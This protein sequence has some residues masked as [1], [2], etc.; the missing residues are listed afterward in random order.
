M[1]DER[2]RQLDLTAPTRSSTPG[3]APLLE[4]DDLRVHFAGGRRLGGRHGVV[5]RAVDGVSF[6]V[7]SG[8]TV[9]VV[10]ES[11]CGKTTLARAI[12]RVNTPT[13]GTIRFRGIDVFA[14]TGRDLTEIRKEIQIVFQ[15]ATSAMNPRMRVA[16]IIGE[17]LRTHAGETTKAERRE[18]VAEL[19][20]LVSLDPKMGE[21]HPH[22]CSGGQRQ[23]IAIARAL[24]VHPALIVCDES[25]A[26]LDVSIQA[27]IINLLQDLKQQLDVA[28][29]FISHDL[30]VV[31]HIA[32]RVVVMYLGRVV[33][34]GPVEK[35]LGDP[36][37]PYTRGLLEAVPVPDPSLEAGRRGANVIRGEVA[38]ADASTTG[39]A[40]A[41]RCPIASKE[42][43]EVTPELRLVALAH[44][45]ACI[46]APSFVD[47]DDNAT[48]LH[49]ADPPARVP[50]GTR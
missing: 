44:T 3:S 6:A 4:V 18:R 7:E 36:Q 17:P 32:D 40:F 2:E 15:D 38:L 26:A 9:A 50:N 37:H 49:R 41:A 33:E 5:V 39:C 31:Y 27:Q 30:S 22:V 19:M 46:K 47:S 8:E 35:V 20:Q 10:G 12:L 14:A 13:S 28:Y 1:S 25:V 21:R 34:E 43:T 29:L 16:D 23:R 24:A 48:G 11:G 42:C 45:A